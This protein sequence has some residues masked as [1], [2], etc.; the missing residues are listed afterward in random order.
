MQIST[1]FGTLPK[2][3]NLSKDLFHSLFE[4]ALYFEHVTFVTNYA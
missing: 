2:R 1:F 4:Q 3:W